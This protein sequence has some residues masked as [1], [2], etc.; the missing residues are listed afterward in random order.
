VL[1]DISNLRFITTLFI[2]VCLLLV[3]YYYIAACWLLIADWKNK[4]PKAINN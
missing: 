4:Q 2:A 1:K 3:G